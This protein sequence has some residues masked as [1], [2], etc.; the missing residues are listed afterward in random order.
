MAPGQGHLYPRRSCGR[1]P[2]PCLPATDQR[3][4]RKGQPRCAGRWFRLRRRRRSAKLQRRQEGGTG[5]VGAT[6]IKAGECGCFA[7]GHSAVRDQDHRLAQ[8]GRLPVHRL[9]DRAAQLRC[10]PHLVE[11]PQPNSLPSLAR[12][13]ADSSFSSYASFVFRGHAAHDSLLRPAET[14]A[15]QGG[16]AWRALDLVFRYPPGR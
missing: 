9:P 15:R 16:A 11:A 1:G 10:H 13:S 4:C 3:C 6:R 8:T 7:Q 2:F 5:Q 12:P 14:G